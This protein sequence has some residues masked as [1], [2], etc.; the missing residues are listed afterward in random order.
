LIRYL[1]APATF[2]IWDFRTENKS[3]DNALIVGI[4]NGK[5]G[6]LNSGVHASQ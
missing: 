4:D 1:V 2:L 3:Y 6:L 5:S